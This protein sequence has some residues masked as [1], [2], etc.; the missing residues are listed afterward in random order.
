VLQYQKNHTSFLTEGDNVLHL[1]TL[2]SKICDASHEIHSELRPWIPSSNEVIRGNEWTKLSKI[3][4]N[5]AA[6]V[7]LVITDPKFF[8]E[9]Y[10]KIRKIH[11]KKDA[12][13]RTVTASL[14]HSQ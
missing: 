14:A 7:D 4:V 2:L 3:R 5:Y 13:A 12:R 1:Y 10:E 6:K 11:G 8:Q 9:A